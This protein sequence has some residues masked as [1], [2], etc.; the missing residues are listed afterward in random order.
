MLPA[1]HWAGGEAKEARKARTQPVTH[2]GAGQTALP[3]AA[4]ISGPGLQRSAPSAASDG[5][6]KLPSLSTPRPAGKTRSAG[7]P[8]ASW[9]TCPCP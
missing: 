7:A 5:T 9:S 1:C 3:A 4:C 6:G 2:L 8:S